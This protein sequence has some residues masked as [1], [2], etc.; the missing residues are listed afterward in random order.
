[1]RQLFSSLLVLH[2]PSHAANV[3]R[4]EAELGRQL[5]PQ[6]I[7]Q[8][9]NQGTAVAVP[10]AWHRAQSPTYG[11]RNTPAQI[12][13]DAANRAAAAA[14]DSQAMIG[15]ANAANQAAAEAAAA[16]VRRRAGGN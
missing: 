10:E 13:A 4:A 1:M 2:Q 7:E 6:E 8:I 5:T 15:G 3:A 12:Q 16:E 14:R 11:G 9:R